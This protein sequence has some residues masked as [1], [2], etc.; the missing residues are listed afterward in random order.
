M[1][2]F[3]K[4]AHH[5]ATPGLEAQLAGARKRRIDAFLQCSKGARLDLQGATPCGDQRGVAARAV[6][7]L[8]LVNPQAE[9]QGIIA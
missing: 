3:A 6:H 7:G 8:M 4:A 9:V 5:H 2:G 1:S